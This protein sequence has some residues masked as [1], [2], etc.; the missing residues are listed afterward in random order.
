[1]GKNAKYKRIKKLA[2]KLPIIGV[3]TV[4]GEIVEGSK[5]IEKDIKEVE[6]KPVSV[7]AKYRSKTIV[8]QPLNHERRIKKA[9]NELGDKGVAMYTQSVKNYVRAKSVNAV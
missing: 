8:P 7:L 5:L 4:R 1:M 9:Y 2:S 3:K 6:G